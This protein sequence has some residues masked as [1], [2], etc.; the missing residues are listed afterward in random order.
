MKL[1][2]FFLH[3]YFYTNDHRRFDDVYLLDGRT[4]RGRWLRLVLQDK[5]NGCCARVYGWDLSPKKN[6]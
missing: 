1:K 3:R 6:R 2:K 5:G 4:N